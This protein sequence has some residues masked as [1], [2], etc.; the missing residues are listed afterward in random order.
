MVIYILL[1]LAVIILILLFAALFINKNYSIQRE[2]IIDQSKEKIFN[3][4]KHLKNQD[5]YSKWVMKDP[6]MNKDFKGTDGTIGFIYS[7]DGNKEAGK[8]EQEIKKII[9]GESIE[10]ELRF[11]K[12][13]K[14][15]G[16]ASMTTHSISPD[17]TKVRWKMEGK[18]PYPLNLM[19]LFIDGILGKDM[20]ESLNNLK[21]ILENK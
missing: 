4:V 21:V 3:Y 12:P 13:F 10:M 15:I 19:N 17:K 18:Q 11:V 1:V 7:W 8:G 5:N 20:N 9:E 14:A 2:I 16:H 6:D